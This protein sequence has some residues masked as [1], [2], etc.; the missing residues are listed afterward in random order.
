[1][2]VAKSD[3]RSM[4]TT[5]LKIT[6]LWSKRMVQWHDIPHT[7]EQTRRLYDGTIIREIHSL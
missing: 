3:S 5:Q 7:P 2:V 6:E 4:S 1:M